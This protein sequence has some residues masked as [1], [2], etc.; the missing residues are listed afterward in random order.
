M[1]K[2]ADY[3]IFTVYSCYLERLNWKVHE[4]TQLQQRNDNEQSHCSDI[5]DSETLSS[6]HRVN[7]AV[8]S[9]SIYPKFVTQYTNMSCESR[10]KKT[11]A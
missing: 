2:Y 4:I 5:C 10:T 7:P 1:I 11:Y 6:P 3:C 9:P 8:Q